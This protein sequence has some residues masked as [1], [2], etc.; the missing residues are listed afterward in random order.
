MCATS[1]SQISSRRKLCFQPLISSSR[2][3]NLVLLIKRKRK[4]VLTSDNYNTIAGNESMRGHRMPVYFMQ[5]DG[6]IASRR[7]IFVFLSRQALFIHRVCS[8]F[9]PRGFLRVG[10]S[11][12]INVYVFM[13]MPAISHGMH[14]VFELTVRVRICVCYNTT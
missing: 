10:P 4:S 14:S 7:L 8:S 13:P 3:G 12:H 5:T 6:D 1:H 11:C 2:H 9:S